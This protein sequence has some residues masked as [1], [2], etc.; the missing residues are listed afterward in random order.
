MNYQVLDQ[1]GSKTILVDGVPQSTYPSPSGGYW[2]N[3]VPTRK[4][5]SVL[6]LG[7]GGGT[8]PRMI[9]K[10]NPKAKIVGVDNDP[11]IIKVGIDHL[12]L[13][14]I[15]MDL[16]LKDIFE[17]VYEIKDKFDLIV[18]DLYSGGSFPYKCLS[19]KFINH[20]KGLLN[21]SGEIYI[22]TPNLEYAV[23]L[24]L[25]TRKAVD[26]GGNIIYKYSIP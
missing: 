1:D 24:Q 9:L 5:D 13:G 22:N 19:P 20:L 26:T 7:V 3:M 6:V 16:I 18:V 11:S 4:V 25:P 21:K 17:Y 2:K 23:T 10:K 8:I 12:A 14:E 15:N